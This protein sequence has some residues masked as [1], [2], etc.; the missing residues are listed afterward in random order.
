MLR[1]VAFGSLMSD[2]KFM[3]FL[4]RLVVMD[5]EASVRLEEQLVT[6]S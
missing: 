1:L 4:L 2:C 5:K 3:K 6:T